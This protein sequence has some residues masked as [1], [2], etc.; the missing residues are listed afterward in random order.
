MRKCRENRIFAVKLIATSIRGVADVIVI[1][2]GVYFVEF[3]TKRGKLSRLQENFKQ[4]CI[5]HCVNYQIISSKEA[6][7][8]FI[9]FLKRA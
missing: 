3:K 7:D 4:I 8:D 9:D 1:R 5:A 6:C 2:K